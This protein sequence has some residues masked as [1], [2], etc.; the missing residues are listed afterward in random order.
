MRRKS[1]FFDVT[2]CCDNGLD[3]VQAHKLVLASCSTFFRR[4]LETIS[5][6]DRPV[7]YLKGVN[8][9][10]LEAV[11]NFMYRGQVRVAQDS[12]NI[13]LCVAEDLEVKGLVSRGGFSGGGRTPPSVKQDDEAKRSF[14]HSKGAAKRKSKGGAAATAATI[15]L[16]ANKVSSPSSSQIHH[17]P[18]G[19]SSS[20]QVT[21]TLVGGGADGGALKE[22][23]V[24]NCDEFGDEASDSDGAGG[25]YRAG[26]DGVKNGRSG[27]SESSEAGN[28]SIKNNIIN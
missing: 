24:G 3:R 21:F 9:A 22:D 17:Q 10:E 18:F 11:L 2:L 15:T 27:K 12:L 5:D 6:V 28:E 13:F 7:I 1:L 8:K 20:T 16:A 25:V 26:F 14:N 23:G 19:G 4:V